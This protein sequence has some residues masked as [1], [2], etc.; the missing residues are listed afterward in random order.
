M[1]P[2]NRVHVEAGIRSDDSGFEAYIQTAGSRRLSKRF[3]PGTP[4]PLIRKWRERTRAELAEDQ[5][6]IEGLKGSMKKSPD[7][8]CYIYFIRSGHGAVKIGKAVDPRARLRELQTAHP[9]SLTLIAAVPAHAALERA[10]HEKFKHLRMEGEWFRLET[11]LFEFIM[12][13]RTGANPVPLLWDGAWHQSWHGH[14]VV[15]KR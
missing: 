10:I 14:V 7:G 13:V 15:P 6:L 2:N 5:R 3:G 4:L 8:W 1:A 12:A 11:D 9:D